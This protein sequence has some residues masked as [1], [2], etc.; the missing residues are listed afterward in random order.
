[1]TAEEAVEK[2]LDDVTFLESSRKLD[3]TKL[4]YYV[5]KLVYDILDYC[6]REDFPATLVYTVTDLIR[7]RIRDED[8]PT[9]E[10]T[11]LAIQGPLSSV[12]MDDTEFHFAVSSVDT[13]KNLAELDFEALKP[14]LNIYRKVV[15]W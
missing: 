5:E 3:E 7:K 9:D 8:S 15:S 6:H 10:D 4:S 2:I 1:M 12:K 14:K 11:G 13:T